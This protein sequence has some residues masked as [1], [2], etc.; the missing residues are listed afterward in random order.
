MFED[1]GKLAEESSAVKAKAC[2]SVY[3]NEQPGEHFENNGHK[4]DISIDDE[5]WLLLLLL[6]WSAS[7][8]F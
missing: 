1:C 3:L 8:S 6:R 2:L 4:M 7:V 5:K